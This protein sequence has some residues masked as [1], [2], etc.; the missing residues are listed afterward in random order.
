MER[1]H[2]SHGERLFAVMQQ[3]D[4]ARGELG[5]ARDELGAARDELGA[6]RDELDAATAALALAREEL[7]VEQELA[8][9]ARAASQH[10]LETLKFQLDCAQGDARELA[11]QLAERDNAIRALCHERASAEA[12]LS[13][14]RGVEAAHT[15][16]SDVAAGLRS[17]LC[18]AVRYGLALRAR[19]AALEVALQQQQQRR[20]Q[21][22]Q[23]CDGVGGW[24]SGAGASIGMD[25]GMGGANARP[26]GTTPWL[27]RPLQ[28]LRGH[29]RQAPPAPPSRC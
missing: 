28:P 3:R 1:L 20:Q 14:Q 11:E 16:S 23:V 7:A 2:E 25:E 17:D 21:Q 12:R 10:A 22:Q 29:H 18:A 13:A 19:C 15:I 26:A 8:A 9:T 5:A 27:P 24:G 6:A 4:A